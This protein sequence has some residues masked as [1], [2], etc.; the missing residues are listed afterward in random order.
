MNIKKQSFFNFPL[1][2]K[3]AS[4]S[5]SVNA[6]VI[7]ILAIVM[8]GLGLGFIRGMFG[9]VSTQIG[10]AVAAEREPSIP[11]AT[12]PITLSREMI[13]TNSGDK[14]VMKVSTFNPTNAAWSAVK[15]VI[16]C[17]DLTIGANDQSANPKTVN[18]GEFVTFNLLFTVP[19]SAP[20]THLCQMSIE[21]Y[22]KDMTIKIVE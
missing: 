3:K 4:L 14:E 19:S 16:S 21:D 1:R 10:E 22:S 5:L 15:P 6:I 11:S 17:L 8:L 20:N 2:K 9:K 7:L 12:E 13:I 18:Q